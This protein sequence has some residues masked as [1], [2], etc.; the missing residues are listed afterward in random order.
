MD[1]GKKSSV[2]NFIASMS[3]AK[4]NHV[5][6]LFREIDKD[7]DGFISRIELQSMMKEL[8]V[9]VLLTILILVRL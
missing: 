9:E 5:K 3:E 2:S 8:G 6:S 1:L 7:N 4:L